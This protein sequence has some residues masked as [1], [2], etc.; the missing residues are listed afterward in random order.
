MTYNV[1]SGTLNP[2]HFTSR[3][4]T[5]KPPRYFTKPF[6]STQH[7]TLCGTGNEYCPE[8]RDALQLGSKGTMAHSTCGINVWVAGKTVRSL[9]NTCQPERFR[10]EFHTNYKALYNCFV[11][12]LLTTGFLMDGRR[13]SD[14][15]ISVIVTP[16]RTV[17]QSP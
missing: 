10:D 11:Y 1:F 9:V 12:I 5:G 6:R 2:T 4:R 13:M 3:V 8:C 17:D 16:V 7:P 15:S 14:A